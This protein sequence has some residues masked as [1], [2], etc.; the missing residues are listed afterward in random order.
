MC[1][2]VNVLRGNL[3]PFQMALAAVTSSPLEPKTTSGMGF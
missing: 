1:P 3:A 2:C